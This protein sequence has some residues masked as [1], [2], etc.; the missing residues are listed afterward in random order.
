MSDPKNPNEGT[1]DYYREKAKTDPDIAALVA[2]I[3]RLQQQL[4]NGLIL[5]T[6]PTKSAGL[7]YIVLR[8]FSPCL[9]AI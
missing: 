4:V 7:R 5:M 2:L 6:K 3:E 1:L 8:N 9:G